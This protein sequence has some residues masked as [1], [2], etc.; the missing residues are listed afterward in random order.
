MKKRSSSSAAHLRSTYRP[1]WLPMAL[2]IA[3]RSGVGSR[4]SRLKNSITPSTLGPRR[5]GRPKAAWSPTRSAIGARGK[6]ESHVTSGIQTDSPESHT[7]PG[8]PTPRA[9]ADVRVTTAKSSNGRDG[10]CHV[11]TQRTTLRARSTSH[12][13]PYCHPSASQTALS[14]RGAASTSVGDSA[15][16]RAVS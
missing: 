9:K 16:A 4:M 6:F 10:G 13:V 1:T 14:M 5:I 2:I 3:S 12:K 8:R 11:P 15:S 7:R